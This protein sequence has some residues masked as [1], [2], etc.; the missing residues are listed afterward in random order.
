MIILI[1][2]ENMVKSVVTIHFIVFLI[3]CVGSIVVWFIVQCQ[4]FLCILFSFGGSKYNT[5]PAISYDNTVAKT[6]ALRPANFNNDEEPPAER[7]RQLEV[8]V[9]IAERSN[10]ALLEELVRTQNEL[11]FYLILSEI[12]LTL[13]EY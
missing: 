8:R 3:L 9:H 4:V 12:D 5:L 2:F 6:G 11:R 13:L 7:L 1:V 10:Q